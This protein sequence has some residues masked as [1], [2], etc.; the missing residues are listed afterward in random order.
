MALLAYL[1]DADRF[2]DRADK[3]EKHIQKFSGENMS[4]Q[5]HRMLRLPA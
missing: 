5:Y 2:I 1:A 4:R 3:A